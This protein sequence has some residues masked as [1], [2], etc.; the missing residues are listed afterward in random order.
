[1]A[2]K[3]AFSVELNGVERSITNVKELKKALKDAKDASLNGDGKAAKAIAD[4]NDK[5]EDL[6][7]STRSLQGSG[8]ERSA[9]SFRLL[10]DGL[11]NL[12]LDKIATGF[13]G[14]GSAMKAIPLLLI[15][16]GVT[17]LIS[18][19]KELSEGSG[20]LAT[21]LQGVGKVID[22]VKGIINDFTDAV[23]WTN[24]ALEKQGEQ[25]K[26]YSENVKEALQGQVSA[27]DRQIAV[28]KA[29]G[30]STIEL[31]QAKQQAIIDT[32]VQVAR[33]IEAFVRAG[34]ALDDE[35]RKLLT[36][37]LEAVK[38][39]RVTQY[40][41]EAADN[42]KDQEAYKKHLEE[43]NKIKLQNEAD[44]KSLDAQNKLLQQ[45]NEDALQKQLVGK[46]LLDKEAELGQLQGIEDKYKQL[47]YES[48]VAYADKEKALKEKYFNESVAV[49]QM[50][51]TAVKGLSDA[52]FAGQLANVEQGSAEELKIKKKQFEV[53]KGLA[54][55]QAIIDGVKG[56]QSQLQAGPIIGPILAGLVGITA[57]VNVN[58]IRKQKFDGGGGAISVPSIGTATL[59]STTA[60]Q[61]NN[62]QQQEGTLLDQN[63]KPITEKPDKQII[64]VVNVVSK[65]TEKQK[66]I[67]TVENRALI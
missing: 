18:N 36:A 53:N 19:F 37:S 39:A 58:N 43:L 48:S 65:T 60:P 1:M 8:V 21:V 67:S 12:D 62:F 6:K 42:K 7:D 26:T 55:T 47:S 4:L 44:Q 64:E 38:N 28:A 34:G 66:E 15:V 46:K 2:E 30:K 51:T 31:E 24:T 9:S 11:K 20:I 56:V 40:V 45:A 33:Q 59:P 10:G 3:I 29:A 50:S 25:I 35:K 49:A 63:G 14:L 27:F 23:G 54:I 16:E 57:A 41:Q 52:L 32:N 5:M 17:Y 61:V 22:Y 13:K